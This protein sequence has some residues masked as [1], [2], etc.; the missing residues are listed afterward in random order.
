MH[1]K[2][3]HFEI[4][5]SDVEQVKKFY[6]ELFDWKITKWDK[7]EYWMVDTGPMSEMGIGGGIT[8][9]EGEYKDMHAFV[10]TV[11]VD[12]LDEYIEKA[13]AAGGEIAVPKMDIPDV[14]SMVYVKDPDGNMFGILQPSEEMMNMGKPKE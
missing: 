8:K 10:S 12:N 4:V 1:K 6:E 11:T 3:V 9:R 7:G 14:G 13:K 5:A 2:V